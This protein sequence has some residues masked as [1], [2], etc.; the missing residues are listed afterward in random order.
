VSPARY[1]IRVWD[2]PTRIFHWTLA[3]LVVFSFTSGKVGGSW[4]DW[5]MRSGYAIL[6]LLIFR[7]AWGLVGSTT[8]RF[9]TFVRGPAAFATYA[10]DLVARRH[11]SIIGH[12][13]M[14]GWM[15]LFML[16]ALLAQAVSG[17]F[18]DDEIATQ[19][20]LAGKVSNAVVARMS[21]F[22][23][24]NGWIIAAVVGIHVIAIA[25]Y[26]WLLK[27][28]RVGPMWSGWR[29]AE[30]GTAQPP[31]RASWLAAILLAMSTAA[32]YWLVVVYPKG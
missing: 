27:D 21:S 6:A 20:P 18:A 11:R 9:A 23:Y 8:S 17:L 14:G 13:P 4:M 26:A 16:A 29:E 30:P 15:V 7:L 10:R 3:V 25:A 19:G 12:N 1:R 2:F 31:S 28:D 5:H 32:V 22:H 24:Y